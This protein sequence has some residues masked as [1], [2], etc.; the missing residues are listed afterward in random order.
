MAEP[1]RP[2]AASAVTD[3]ISREIAKIHQ[4]SYGAA[5]RMVTTH[6]LDDAVISVIEMELLRHEQLIAD[7]GGQASVQEVRR[8]FQ[9][10]IGTTFKATVEHMTGRRVIGF[11]RDTHVDPS[12]SGEFFKLSPAQASRPDPRGPTFGPKGR[13]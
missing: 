13:R 8:A 9:E 6:L 11:L 1:K 4:E 2:Q 10:A 7:N 5:P 12:F 3:G